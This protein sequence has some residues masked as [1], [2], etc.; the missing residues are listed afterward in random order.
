MNEGPVVFGLAGAHAGI[1]GWLGAGEQARQGGRS[2]N[3]GLEGSAIRALNALTF[4]RVAGVSAP[5]AAG[6]V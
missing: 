1:E 4:A 2:R 5:T 6:L 3:G